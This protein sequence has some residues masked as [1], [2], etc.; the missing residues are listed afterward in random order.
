MQLL[1][2]VNG[3][4][5]FGEKLL[6]NGID[7]TISKGDKIALVAKNGSGKTTLLKIIAGI[8]SLD[9]EH[10]EIELSDKVSTYYLKQVPEFHPSD[11]VE[12][13]IY[14]SENAKIKAVYAYE[15]AI[16]LPTD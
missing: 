15:K 16:G 14:N 13:V 5:R 3:N 12:D 10:V 6:L 11:T 1:K 7:I 8:E 4:K 2:I 9:G